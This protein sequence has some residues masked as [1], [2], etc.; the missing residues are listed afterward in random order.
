MGYATTVLRVVTGATMAGH[1]IQKLSHALG[2]HGPEGTAKAFEGMGFTPGRPFGMAAGM[3]ETAGGSM[4]ALG[5]GVPLACSM[6]TGVM[7]GAIGKVHYKN[8]FWVT[9]GGFEYNLHILA[10]TFAVAGA[11]GGALTLDGLRRKK[12]RGFGWA[13]AQL[14][15][16]AGAAAAALTIAER[17]AQAQGVS[18]TPSTPGTQTPGHTDADGSSLVDLA[19]NGSMH[20]SAE[21]R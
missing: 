6:V 15:V 8:G 4:M 7:A 5:L 16:G 20:E 3:A 9:D 2:G 10:A 18:S 14:A 17:Q 12:H 11:G 19:G 1:G 21:V 13:V